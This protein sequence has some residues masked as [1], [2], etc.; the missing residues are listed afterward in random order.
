MAN[1]TTLWIVSCMT[2]DIKAA[3]ENVDIVCGNAAQGQHVLDNAEKT[4]LTLIFLI[5]PE[6]LLLEAA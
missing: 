1:F 6:L 5:G 4:A 3:V 2:S